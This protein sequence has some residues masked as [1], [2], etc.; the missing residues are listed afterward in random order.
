MLWARQSVPSKEKA[1]RQIKAELLLDG[2]ALLGVDALAPGDGDLA[3]GLDFLLSEVASRGLPYVSANLANREGALVFPESLV[4][5]RAGLKIGITSV[6]SD[7]LHIAG[8][9]VL[10][11]QTSLKAVVEKLRARDQVDLILVLSHLGLTS[12]K[13]LP[14]QVPGIDLIF[15]GHSRSHQEDPLL[16]GDT[17]IFQAGSRGK[18]LG[19]VTLSLREAG[20][21]WFDPGAQVR[22]TA[23]RD[24]L[25][26]QIRDYKV[27]LAALEP[28]NESKRSRLERVV[29]FSQR[30][31]DVLPKPSPKSATSNLLNSEKIP[32]DRGLADH[33]EM[34]ALVDA[35]LIRLGPEGHSTGHEGHNHG[36]EGHN[37][38]HEAAKPKPKVRSYGDFVGAEA[39]KACHQG[40]YK[41][42]S[43]TRHA[44][45]YATLVKERR[46]F[47]LDC[48]SC[49]V[50]GAN[51][52][53]GPSGPYDVGPM[54]NVQCE[55]C[56]GAGRQH[57]ADPKV[58]M[59]RVPSEEH[60]KSCHSDEQ[61]EGRFEYNSYL[62]RVDHVD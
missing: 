62:P 33:K 34:A 25:V 23:Q 31:L 39:C 7:E 6:L 37:H 35:A 20:V 42:W 27:Q 30:R 3:F 26:E 11:V 13:A 51:L 57:V 17:A 58:D 10:P 44:H 46:H 12:D 32:L 22:T 8:G 41:D 61:T 18:H 59:V 48:W 53:G 5:A 14:S 1:Q 55:S 45:A 29:E 4:V 52:K 16:V 9:R 36:H 56:H 24:Q 21:G 49:H 60:C 40:Q 15:G 47:D 54:R 28:E 50:T 43:T 38:G 19:Q 2:V